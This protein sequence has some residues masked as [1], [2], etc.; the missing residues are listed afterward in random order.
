MG[1]PGPHPPRSGDRCVQARGD[2]DAA[3]SSAGAGDALG[4]ALAFGRTVQRGVSG[5]ALG[6][7]HHLRAE[8]AQ[9][10]LDQVVGL[11]SAAG[12][13]QGLQVINTMDFSVRSLRAWAVPYAVPV[14][15]ATATF[16]LP[17]ET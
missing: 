17:V 10:R 3:R 6:D 4:R 1:R 2:C 12:G 14:S 15:G 8:G 11:I 9:L 16:P 5:E 13:I 7:A